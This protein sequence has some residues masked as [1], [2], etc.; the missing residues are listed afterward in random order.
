MKTYNF[1]FILILAL[2]FG[3]C[4]SISQGKRFAQCQFRATT[5][6]NMVLA[7]VALPPNLQDISQ[8]NFLEAAQIM[9]TF[10]GG[11]EFP[12]TFIQNVEVQ[13][14]NNEVAAI[15]RLEWILFVDDK[16]ITQGAND[17]R[18]EIQPNAITNMPLS[19]KIDLRKVINSGAASAFTNLVLNL[20]KQSKKPS[21][22]TLK[23]KPSFKIAG[24][25]MPYPGYISLTQ[26]FSAN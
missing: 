15:N 1:L 4:K 16:E 12:L 25:M 14:P 2:A 18:V 3:S 23:V 20:L 11:G 13:N 9:A 6:D 5:M 19:F 7:G 26:Q 22:I 21:S 10:S 24:M 17:Q 8:L